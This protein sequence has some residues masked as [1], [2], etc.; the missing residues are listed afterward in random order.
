MPAYPHVHALTLGEFK[1]RLRNDYG[2]V[3]DKIEIPGP[4]GPIELEFLIRPGSEE[5]IAELPPEMDDEEYLAPSTL[6]SLCSQLALDPA[7]F[8]LY[9]E[10]S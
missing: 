3:L 9:M 2:A 1:E 7:D 5:H 8:G 6:R 10:E 4:H